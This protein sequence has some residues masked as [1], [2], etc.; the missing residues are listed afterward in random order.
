MSR[1]WTRVLLAT[2]CVTLVGCGGDGNDD[3]AGQAPET[4]SSS[5]PSELPTLPVA[6]VAPQ[7]GSSAA[8][9]DGLV[10]AVQGFGSRL[11]T[12]KPGEEIDPE[13]G[14]VLAD[15]AAEASRVLADH[16]AAL[17]ENAPEVRAPMQRLSEIY[18]EMA[19]VSGGSQG[20]PELL[21]AREPVTLQAEAACKATGWRG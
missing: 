4:A 10:S 13:E 11:F 1:A 20:N 17:G 9:C 8:A 12:L 7:Q 18:A 2:A 19:K 14:R 3:E 15:A 16:A 6:S 21:Q 5:S